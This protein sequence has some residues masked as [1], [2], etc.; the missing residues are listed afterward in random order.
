MTSRKLHG[1]DP[2]ATSGNITRNAIAL[3]T[4]AA[5]LALAACTPRA[6]HKEA[7]PSPSPSAMATTELTNDAKAELS[8][9][10]AIEAKATKALVAENYVVVVY[11]GADSYRTYSDTPTSDSKKHQINENLLVIQRPIPN[12]DQQGTLWLGFTFGTPG[13][14]DNEAALAKQLYWVNATELAHNGDST[15][16]HND[17]NGSPTLVRYD[18]RDVLEHKG[19]VAF[20]LPVTILGEG[21]N[22]T[23]S[24]NAAAQYNKGPSNIGLGEFMTIDQF[25]NSVTNIGGIRL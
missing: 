21:A 7:A 1:K 9:I 20:E 18:Y 17:H 2:S 22:A 10:K 5:A 3:A 19:Q 11:G 13:H 15:V 24:T 25:E 16:F 6:S 12:V 8:L 23:L 4:T 14:A